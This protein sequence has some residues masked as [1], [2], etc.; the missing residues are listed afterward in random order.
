[1]DLAAHQ[2]DALFDISLQRLFQRTELL[3]V[4]C[5]LARLGTKRRGQVIGRNP[6]QGGYARSSSKQRL[7]QGVGV[8]SEGT[9]EPYPCNHNSTI[10]VHLSATNLEIPP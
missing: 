7:P 6:L 2:L 9:D 10:Q 4:A 8:V 1:L 5:E 3:D